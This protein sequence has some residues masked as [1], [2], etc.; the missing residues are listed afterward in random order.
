MKIGLKSYNIFE[1]NKSIDIIIFYNKIFLF[2]KNKK[3]INNHASGF[4]NIIIGFYRITCI[5]LVSNE[6]KQKMGQYE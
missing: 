1:Q 4:L 5:K 6:M 2:I 3:D